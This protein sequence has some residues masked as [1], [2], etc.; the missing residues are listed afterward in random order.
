MVPYEPS[1]GIPFV[2]AGPGVRAGHRSDALVSLED[3]AAT[4]LDHAGLQPAADMT[5]RSLRAVL[6]GTEI[7]HRRA[8]ISG[9]DYPHGRW[10]AVITQRYKLVVRRDGEQNALYDRL[11]DPGELHNVAGDHPEVVTSL[12]ETLD[13]LACGITS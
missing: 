7:E 1:V 4:V 2:V 6:D 10:R 12:T 5:A 8:V 13:S 11:T 3:I 9:L